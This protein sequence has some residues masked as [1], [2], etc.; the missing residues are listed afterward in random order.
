MKKV[1]FTLYI[2][3][4]TLTLSSCGVASQAPSYG[5]SVSSRN[6]DPTVNPTITSYNEYTMD[7]DPEPVTYTI[8]ISTPDG[9][10]KLKDISL[11]EAK[12]LALVE[13]IMKCRCATLFNP[14]YTHLVKDNE[15]L[16]VTVYGYPA[17]YKATEKK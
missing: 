6:A 2:V 14:Q 9:R 8:D 11:I 12:E 4:A 10:Q 1:F 15:V 16:R 7:L 5:S 3:C 13:A 17:R